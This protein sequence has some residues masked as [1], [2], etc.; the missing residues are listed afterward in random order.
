MIRKTVTRASLIALAAVLAIELA[1]AGSAVAQEMIA[2]GQ[3]DAGI[4]GWHLLSLVGVVGFDPERDASDSDRSGSLGMIHQEPPEGA[5]L[6]VLAAR[7]DCLTG[8][9]GGDA[10]FFGGTL[11]FDA[12]ETSSG[13]AFVYIQFWSTTTCD[14]GAPSKVLGSFNTPVLWASEDRG[15]WQLVSFGGPRSGAIA[16]PGTQSMRLGVAL[17]MTQGSQLTLNVDDAYLAPVGTPVC[18][19]LPA[20]II[21]TEDDDFLVGT[22]GS[23]VI[24]GRRGDD[25]IDGNGGNDRICGGRGNDSICAGDG[26]DRVWGGRGTDYAYGSG[27]DDVLRGGSGADHLYGGNDDDDLRGGAGADSCDGGQGSD[28]PLTGC[29]AEA[30]VP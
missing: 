10:F 5:A 15:E 16:P 13:Y 2:N 14:S 1:A 9:A 19:G 21:G 20:T 3:F 18:G 30:D 22:E 23:D 26:D 6:Y 8:I 29:E 4:G 28:G 17:T 12:A 11:R 7:H 25:T 27:D 24:V